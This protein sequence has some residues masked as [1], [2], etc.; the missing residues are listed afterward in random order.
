MVAYGRGAHYPRRYGGGKRESTVITAAITQEFSRY[1]LDT[2]DGSV[3]AAEAFA[4]GKAIDGVWAVNRRLAGAEI[5]SR[6]METLT[7]WE[8]ILRLR[9]VVSDSDTARRQAVAAK[10]RALTGHM[11]LGDI[12]D[13]CRAVMGAS[14]VQVTKAAPS[15]YM[16]YMPGGGGAAM[17]ALPAADWGQFAPGAPGFE[18]ST[19]RCMLAIVVEQGILDNE[20]YAKLRA[21]LSRLLHSSLP[22]YITFEIGEGAAGFICD[23]GVCDITFV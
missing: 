20:T 7:T 13:I 14:F 11:T 4:F 6:M 22:A 12:A 8:E 21:S 1:R 5:P 23:V 18:N 15:D 19:N 9:P 16:T 2:S 17:A 3:K 10:F